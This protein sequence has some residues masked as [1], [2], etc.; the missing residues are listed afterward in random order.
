MAGPWESYEP[1]S[2][3]VPIRGAFGQKLA[4]EA[5]KI[6]DEETAL[7]RVALLS[8]LPSKCPDDALDKVGEVLRIPRYAGQSS[9]TYRAA[10]EQAWPTHEIQGSADAIEEQIRA[11]GI[12]DVRVYTIDDRNFGPGP[13]ASNFSQFWVAIGPDVGA[14]V[15]LDA[16]RAIK[17][18]ILKW[19]AAHG[20]PVEILIIPS[21]TWVLGYGSTVLGDGT[22]MGGA[23]VGRVR[24]GRTLNGTWGTLGAGAPSCVLGGYDLT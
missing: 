12:P 20:Y 15:G 8:R 11:F 10:L 4:T 2:L 23:D 5:G 22:P 1:T 16:L 3:R 19:K 18:I 24:I 21:D 13:D 14:G 9:A 6:R 7:L 17:R